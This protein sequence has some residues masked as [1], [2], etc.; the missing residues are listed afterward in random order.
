MSELSGGKK[1]HSMLLLIFPAA[2]LRLCS[3]L[4]VVG[5]EKKCI[6]TAKKDMQDKMQLHS[7]P[8]KR[9]WCDIN[10]SVLT[11]VSTVRTR[12]NVLGCACSSLGCTQ[13]R[14]V[15]AGSLGLA[16]KNPQNI[17]TYTG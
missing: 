1:W 8:F 16:A 13:N 14:T 6:P 15:R 7:L 2:P 5:I 9:Y 17:T 10:V 4:F 12:L 11:S 3:F